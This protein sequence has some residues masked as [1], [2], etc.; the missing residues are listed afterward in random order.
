MAWNWKAAGAFLAAAIVVAAGAASFLYIQKAKRP[1]KEN[2]ALRPMRVRVAAVQ[3]RTIEQALVLTGEIRPA[4]TVEIASKIP[5][6]IERLEL[7]D[8]T[9]VTEGT[10]VRRGEVL[11]VLEHRDLKSRVDEAAAASK[12]AEAAVET[13]KAALPAAQAA[14]EAAN[15]VLSDAKRERD[16]FETLFR[17]GSATERQK[18]MAEVQLARAAAERDRAEAELAAARAKAAQAEAALEQ[19]R[20]AL[21]VA[22]A[23]LEEAFIRAP[24][25]GVVARRY[26][27]P[28]AMVAPAIPILRL[29]SADRLR[30]LVAVPGEFLPRLSEETPVE[31]SVE[32]YPGRRFESRISKIYP[33]VDPATRTATLEILIQNERDDR[34]RHLLRPG[35]YATAKVLIERRPNAVAVPAD[36]II[37]RLEKHY[38]FV[39]EG[40]VARRR[41]VK[42]G[43]RTRT[44]I[45][46]LEGLTVGEE[47]VTS[48]HERLADGIPVERVA[49]NTERGEG[50]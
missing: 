45:E 12:T 42:L 37:R 31:I 20:A 24:F 36:A 13:A 1:A 3:A 21:R 8:G 14:L 2:A 35:L 23:A 29:D 30:A 32:A 50:E 40:G 43:L 15:V 6:R 19:A 27:D 38:A 39:V 47:L 18:E 17:E 33:A 34:G 41:E 4:A 44:E 9:E 25:D 28:G 11:V 26:L 7:A 46:I 16:R 10:V 48:G 5:G 22:E 49:E